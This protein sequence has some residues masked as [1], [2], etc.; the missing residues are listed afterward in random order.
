MGYKRHPKKRIVDPSSLQMIYSRGKETIIK[1]AAEFSMSED[2]DVG[3]L[4][5]SPTGEVTTYASKGRVEDMLISYIEEQL[6]DSDGPLENAEFLCQSLK[7]LKIEA[8]KKDKMD[9]CDALQSKL[10]DLNWL[11]EKAEEKLRL[12]K[13][14]LSKIDSVAEADCHQAKL[15]EEEA[16]SSNRTS[17]GASTSGRVGRS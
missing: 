3:V 4:M 8:E 6:D 10:N 15:L 7:R 9:R 1:K 11:K 12:F 2:T 14:D 16:S 5:F 13:P 17:D